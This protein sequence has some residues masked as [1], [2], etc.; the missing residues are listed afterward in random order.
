MKDI[1]LFFDLIFIGGI[2]TSFYD[3]L[4]TFKDSKNNS[5]SLAHIYQYFTQKETVNTLSKYA[6][7]V[8]DIGPID[9][10]DTDIFIS[11]TIIFPYK[12]VLEKVKAKYKIGWLHAIPTQQS[13]NENI[14]RYRE[15]YSQYDYWVCVSEEVKK[16]LKKILP[17]AKCEVIHNTINGKR[18]KDLS[19]ESVNMKKADLTFVTSARIGKEKGYDKAIEFIDKIHNKGINY[20]WYIIGIG[21]DPDMVSMIEDAM[22]KYN[23]VVVGYDMNPYKYIARADYGLLMSPLESWSIFYDECHILGIPTITLDLPVY[24]ERDNP[25]KMGM[26]LKPDL[27]NLNI[28]LLQFKLREYKA[29]LKKY[30]YHNDYDKWENLFNRLK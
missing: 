16:G 4:Y 13:V 15:Y 28:D 22:K 7:R 8:S 1:T 14:F 21:T 25:E 20:V 12:E 26:L 17:T 2:E 30:E 24:H 23:I 5:L 9:E 10:Y 18:I 29:Y 6:K 11:A 27:S 19:K 3:L